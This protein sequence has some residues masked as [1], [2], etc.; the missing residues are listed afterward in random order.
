MCLNILDD[1]LFVADAHDNEQRKCFYYF[2]KAL[3]QKSITSKQLFLMGDM[4]DFITQ[5]SHYFIQQNQELI[6]MINTL[7]NTIEIIYLEGN[8]DYN[9][10][11]LFPKVLVVPREK[12]PLIAQY[13]NQKIALSHGD[14]F[15][16]FSYNV[17]CAI[18]RNKPLLRFLNAID[19]NF[20]LSKRIEKALSVKTI[21]K[22]FKTF[23]QLVEKRIQ[24]YQCDVVIEGHFHQ[25]GVYTLS[26]TS[27]VNI[28]SLYCQQAYVQL[29]NKEFKT[30]KLKEESL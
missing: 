14:N 1:A 4:F 15:T 2:L 24:N 23:A 30:I 11:L 26:N 7:S 10:Q 5:E 19:F 3:L 17:Y 29:S 9:L 28:P 8:H 6:K 18:I 12:Q 16:P 25:G 20:W 22:P 21:C 27:Y 13:Q